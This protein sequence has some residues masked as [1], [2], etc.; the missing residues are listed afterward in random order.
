MGKWH[1]YGNPPAHIFGTSV[2][3]PIDRT[4]SGQVYNMRINAFNPHLP[5]GDYPGFV[6]PSAAVQARPVAAPAAPSMLGIHPLAARVLYR[7]HGI[8]TN[9]GS[10]RLLDSAR[11]LMAQVAYSVV[12]LDTHYHITTFYEDN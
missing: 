6:G 3:M 11:L 1:T 10:V 9:T 5:S 2:T 7:G 8:V 4:T 12:K